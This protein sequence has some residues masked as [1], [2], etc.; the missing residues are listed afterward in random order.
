MGPLPLIALPF[1][2]EE[3]GSMPDAELK[4]SRLPYWSWSRTFGSDATWEDVMYRVYVRG[5]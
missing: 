3:C 1:N 5:R 2:D 4:R